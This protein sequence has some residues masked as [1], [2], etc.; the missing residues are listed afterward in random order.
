MYLLFIACRTPHARC[1]CLLFSVVQTTFDWLWSLVRRFVPAESNPDVMNKYVAKM[2]WPV[3]AY[4][5]VGVRWLEGQEM[6]SNHVVLLSRV[7]EEWLGKVFSLPP[8]PD[9]RPLRSVWSEFSSKRVHMVA[10]R[11]ASER[12]WNLL[13]PGSAHA[14]DQ[15]RIHSWSFSSALLFSCRPPVRGGQSVFPLAP[16]AGQALRPEAHPFSWFST[17]LSPSLLYLVPRWEKHRSLAWRFFTQSARGFQPHHTMWSTFEKRVRRGGRFSAG[18]CV[19]SVCTRTKPGTRTI[20]LSTWTV[21]VLAHVLKFPQ[22]CA[23]RTF[24]V[25]GELRAD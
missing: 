11:Y 6:R 16:H 10:Y 25:F 15:R 13:A 21:R 12:R 18:A 19:L 9:Y 1:S 22:Y 8:N 24:H 20:W 3:G 17:S 4:R 23:W 7:S 5:W 2:G 14:A